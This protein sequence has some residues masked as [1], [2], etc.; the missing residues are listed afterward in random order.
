LNPLPIHLALHGDGWWT[1]TITAPSGKAVT[2]RTDP[3]TDV[4][5]AFSLWVSALP[6]GH[7][8]DAVLFEEEPEETTV[9]IE[10]GQNERAVR[11]VIIH[12]E[13]RRESV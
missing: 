13:W 10:S 6:E 12:N 8:P 9:K 2:T 1:C 11:I 3:G 5:Q 4:A 7:L